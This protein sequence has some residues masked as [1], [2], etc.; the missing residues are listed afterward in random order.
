MKKR[1]AGDEILWEPFY[2]AADDESRCRVRR[3]VLRHWIPIP[4]GHS[5]RDRLN[6]GITLTIYPFTEH[7]VRCM[8]QSSTVTSA[9]VR[10]AITF[11]KLSIVKHLDE[12]LGTISLQVFGESPKPG[13]DRS[14]R[15]GNVSYT[16][17]TAS[18]FA[19]ISIHSELYVSLLRSTRMRVATA[20]DCNSMNL[21]IRKRLS[22]LRKGS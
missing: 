3:I 15:Y 7:D 4:K 6:Q 14:T 9:Y 21:K 8:Q 10:P 2:V 22:S 12:D 13:I 19:L 18:W 20:A 1:R 5:T 16:P 17:E 11:L